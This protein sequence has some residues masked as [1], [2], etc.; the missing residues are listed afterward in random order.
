M[1]KHAGLLF[2]SKETRRVFLILEDQKWTVPTFSRKASLFDDA[3]PLLSTYS[4]GKIIPIEL[5]L[6][7]DNGFEYGTYMCLVKNE[8]LNTVNETVCWSSL[9][10]LPK[11]LHVGLKNTLSNS[12]IRAKIDTVLELEK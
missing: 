12:I 6:S 1:Q 5:Y 7:A 10:Y 8:F 2:L 4:E 3:Q 9:D 11:H